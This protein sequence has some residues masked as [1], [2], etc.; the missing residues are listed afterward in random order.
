MN[1]VFRALAHPVRRQIL[2]MLRDGPMAAGAIAAAFAVSK[3][4]MSGH[5]NVL[6]EAGLVL[7]EREGTT[8]RYRLN[9]SVAEEAL[10][11]LMAVL[12]VRAPEPAGAQAG[13]KAGEEDTP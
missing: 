8:I 10:A 11:A 4:T 7:A 12:G 9:V 6:K 1:D 2:A 5:F 3:P 13:D